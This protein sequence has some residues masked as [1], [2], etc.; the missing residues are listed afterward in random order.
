VR[1]PPDIEIVKRLADIAGSQGIVM[2]E[3]SIKRT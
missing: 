3:V 2:F 1:D